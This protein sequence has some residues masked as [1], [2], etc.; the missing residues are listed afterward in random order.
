MEFVRSFLRLHFAGKPP[1][2]SRNVVCFLRLVSDEEL[3][4]VPWRETVKFSTCSWLTVHLFCFIEPLFVAM[5]RSH[6]IASSREAFYSW[7]YRS[8]KKLTAL[9]LQTHSKRKDIRERLV[10]ISVCSSTLLN[11]WKPVRTKLGSLHVSGKL[12]TY[13]SPKPTLTLTSHLGQNVSLG[14]GYERLLLWRRAR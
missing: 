7:Q 2:A 9:E 11:C 1:V 8:P 5:T 6:V 10:L 4:F 3:F 13:P 14:E 12:P